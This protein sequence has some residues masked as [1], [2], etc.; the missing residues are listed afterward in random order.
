MGSFWGNGRTNLFSGL[1]RLKRR[2][3]T[4]RLRPGLETEI[5]VMPAY[6]NSSETPFRHQGWS[7]SYL[8]MNL[9]WSAG[10]SSVVVHRFSP[11]ININTADAQTCRVP[12][13]LKYSWF[14]YPSIRRSGTLKYCFVMFWSLFY[15][16]NNKFLIEHY[17]SHSL[18]ISLTIASTPPPSPSPCLLP[19]VLHSPLGRLS[20]RLGAAIDR[21]VKTALKPVTPLSLREQ[22]PLRKL[23]YVLL[24]NWLASALIITDT[25]PGFEMAWLR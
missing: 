5:L 14:T 4:L 1:H 10:W 17:L 25:G 3:Q 11:C 13:T 24:F 22:G 16:K 12:V 15:P 9:I 2:K 19:S 8:C 6:I 23:L 21:H 7:A 20:G 18:R